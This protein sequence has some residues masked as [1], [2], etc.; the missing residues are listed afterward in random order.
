MRV[1]RFVIFIYLIH[2]H[3]ILQAANSIASVTDHFFRSLQD[4]NEQTF[5][6]VLA[7]ASKLVIS[8]T[9]DDTRVKCRF[10]YAPFNN[11]GVNTIY[12]DPCQRLLVNEVKSSLPHFL[13]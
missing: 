9:N 2:F 11:Y 1:K 5:P 13:I 4:V 7:T 6:A 8:T 3:Y 12:C 10:C